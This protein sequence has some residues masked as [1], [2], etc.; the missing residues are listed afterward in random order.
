MPGEQDYFVSA[1]SELNSRIADIEEKQR[2]IK[3]RMLLVGKNL[4]DMR[5]NIN[6]DLTEIKLRLEGLEQNTEKLKQAFLRIGDELEKKARKSELEILEKQ[7]K[8]FE[9]LKLARLEDVER[10]VE[11][12]LKEI[13][14]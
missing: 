1:L 9:P 8:M 5:E 12:K 3:D 14:K 11:N 7:M 13:K 6:K 2:L 10:I 4:V